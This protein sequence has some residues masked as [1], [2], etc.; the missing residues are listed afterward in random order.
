MDDFHDKTK[1]AFSKVIFASLAFIAGFSLIFILL[2][3]SA[4]FIGSFLQNYMNIIQKIAGVIVVI[5]GLHLAGVFQLKFLMYEKKFHSQKGKVGPIK[6]FI[7][8]LAFAAGWTPCIGP[9]LA[10]ILFLASQQ[11]TV[12]H[13]IF[14]LA[15]YSLGLAIPFFLTALSL[16]LFFNLF[17]KIQK[18]FKIIEI[19]AGIFLILVGIMIFFGV[20]QS[21]SARLM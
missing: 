2:G 6:G 4:T 10:P 20:L 19:I 21:L 9:I 15:V 8:G 13:G 18:H 12:W 7:M 17:K 11:S 1:G 3:A 14:M 16:R 5:F